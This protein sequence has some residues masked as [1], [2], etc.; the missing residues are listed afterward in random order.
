ME[1][2]ASQS[3]PGDSDEKRTHALLPLPLGA[4]AYNLVE[5]ERTEDRLRSTVVIAALAMLALALAG[6]YLLLLLHRPAEQITEWM[7]G[8]GLISAIASAVTAYYFGGR[9]R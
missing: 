9:N 2:E 7:G 1:E 4:P 6:L 5:R 8:V 3:P